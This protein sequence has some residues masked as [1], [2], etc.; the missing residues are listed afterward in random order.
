MRK[1]ITGVQKVLRTPGCKPAGTEGRWPQ[2]DLEAS[3]A[4]KSPGTKAPISE[5]LPVCREAAQEM[6]PGAQKSR[7]P[8]VA[9]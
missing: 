3:T 7:S 9:G 2:Q 6:G 8:P 1:Q 5:A 4:E